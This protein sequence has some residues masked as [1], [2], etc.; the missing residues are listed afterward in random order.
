[1][2]KAAARPDPPRQPRELTSRVL[3]DEQAEAIRKGLAAGVRGPVLI[4]WCGQL[5]AD[6][7]ARAALD[8][9]REAL[10]RAIAGALRSQ[11]HAHGPIT[12]DAIGS[13]TKRV[14]GQLRNARAK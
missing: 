4:K 6:R 10:E 8:G 9:D 11:I 13:A 1:M 14:L 3:T 12:L 2:A 5:L 7:D